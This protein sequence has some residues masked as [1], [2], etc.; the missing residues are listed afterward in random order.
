MPTPAP[1]GSQRSWVV[2]A[3]VLAVAATL[4]AYILLSGRD[5]G[6]DA[7]Q[8][9]PAASG[10]AS[11]SPAGSAT[12]SDEAG[13]SADADEDASEDGAGD[14]GASGDDGDQ[15]DLSAVEVR[16]EGDLLAA[17]PVDAPVGLVVFSD[18]QCPYCARWNAETLPAMMEHAEAGDLR[19]EWRD[20]N[21]FGA[22]S[23]RAS[24]AAYAAARQD[25]FWEYHD[26][27]FADGRT[28]SE[29]EL[30]E[31]A[32][33]DLAGELELDTDRFREDLSSERTQQAVAAHQQLGTDLGATATPVFVL[34]GEAIVGAQPTEVF[35]K[36]FDEAL[37]EAR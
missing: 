7:Q 14:D 21:V 13:P 6:D 28:R 33:V 5:A 24:R 2:P 30:R 22:G 36:A 31:E 34:D 15:Q 3:V 9:R 29:A 4:I 16:D 8:P 11:P 35:E 23:E 37:A 10:A 26:A 27:L 20:V 12:P 1:K 19:I 32:L 18:Y 17:G 25:A